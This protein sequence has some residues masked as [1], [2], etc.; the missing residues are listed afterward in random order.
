MC[1]PITIMMIASSAMQA[2]Q[3]MDQAKRM[4]QQAA[5]QAKAQYEASKQQA[6]A[7]YAEANRKIAEEQED[8]LDQ[9]SER[10]RQSNEDIGSLQASETSLSNSSL[11]LIMFEEMYGEALNV[12]RIDKNSARALAGLESN[13]AAS[14][15]NY[16]NVTT[17]AENQAGNVMAE[18]SAKK[19]GA[20]LGFASTSLS[21]GQQY[22]ARQDTLSAIRGEPPKKSFWT[23][24]L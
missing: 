10:V 5:R 21:A 1:D 20:I 11:G 16:S 2:K 6:E 4:E 14:E 19:T 12:T 24:P 8:N 17:Q 9:Q 23:T 22:G 3:Q 15:Q 13:K 7:E 18:A